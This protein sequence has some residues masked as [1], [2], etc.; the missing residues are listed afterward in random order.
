MGV[1]LEALLLTALLA[2]ATRAVAPCVAVLDLIS[3][4]C[5]TRA[6]DAGVRSGE[7]GWAVVVLRLAVVAHTGL[8]RLVGLGD[9]L[10]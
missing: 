4:A 5:P 1:V 6:V 2:H 7:A 3:R 8:R 9:W 10:L